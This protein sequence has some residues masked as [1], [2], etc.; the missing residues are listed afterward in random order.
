MHGRFACSVRTGSEITHSCHHPIPKGE[1]ARPQ[2]WAKWKGLDRGHRRPEPGSVSGL[3]ISAWCSLP[4]L[5]HLEDFCAEVGAHAVMITDA[6]SASG[7]ARHLQP[8]GFVF[9]VIC[10]F[11]GHQM[12]SWLVWRLG[13]VKI[14]CLY[15]AGPLLEGLVEMRLPAD[16]LTLSGPT[17]KVDGKTAADGPPCGFT[18]SIHLSSIALSVLREY[19][20]T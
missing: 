13:S 19:T 3:V 18:P 15:T 9:C 17:H 10:S 20:W 8:M 1:N 6:W 5:P 4:L 14:Q 12:T 16:L 7:P 11:F 2:K